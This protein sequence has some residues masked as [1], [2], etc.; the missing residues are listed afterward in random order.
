MVVVGKVKCGGLHVRAPVCRN[1]VVFCTVA[2]ALTGVPVSKAVI[3]PR[4]AA[5]ARANCLLALDHA[6]LIAHIDDGAISQRLSARRDAAV[7]AGGGGSARGGSYSARLAERQVV[8]TINLVH[9]VDK[10]MDGKQDAVW[11]ILNHMRELCQSQQAYLNPATHMASA[12]VAAARASVMMKA[13]LAAAA[14]LLT[15]TGAAARN[16]GPAG[17][18]RTPRADAA[19]AASAAPSQLTA[20]AAA[21]RAVQRPAPAAPQAPWRRIR[22]VNA[23]LYGDTTDAP[24]L[25]QGPAE[26]YG[27]VGIM[28]S[29]MGPM[30]FTVGPRALSPGRQALLSHLS[31]SVSAMRGD[32]S[33]RAE[34]GVCMGLGDS[35]VY[36]SGEFV[37]E[38]V[39]QMRSKSE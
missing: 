38:G 6:G 37:S 21:Q 24:F 10:L 33:A 13:R 16:G 5:D 12:R 4:N 32:A 14:E 34:A 15:D 8:A 30:I 36:G 28:P 25:L 19:T 22:E 11:V 1:G 18:P 3:P 27:P 20:M 23:P 26:D 7:A 31:Q 29:G 35:V 39:E 17:K 2:A 9:E